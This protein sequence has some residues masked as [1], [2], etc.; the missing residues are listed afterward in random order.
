VA[1]DLHFDPILEPTAFGCSEWIDLDGMT[2][3]G[4]LYDVRVSG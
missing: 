4:V 2:V 3:S 1:Q